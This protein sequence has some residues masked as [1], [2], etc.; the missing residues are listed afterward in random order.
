MIAPF[1]ALTYPIDKLNDGQ[2]QGFNK[3]LKEYIFNLLIQPMHLLLYTILRF[4]S[5]KNFR[6]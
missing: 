2:A 3:W 1:V 6:K 5:Y 4:H